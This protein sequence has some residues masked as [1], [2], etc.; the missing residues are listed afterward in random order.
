MLQQL[1]EKWRTWREHVGRLRLIPL[2]PPPSRATERLQ[3][4]R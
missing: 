4:P 2:W 3:R 1:R